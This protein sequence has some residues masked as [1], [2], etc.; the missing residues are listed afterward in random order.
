MDGMV[1]NTMRYIDDRLTLNV[2]LLRLSSRASAQENYGKSHSTLL[3][4]VVSTPQQFMIK[5]SFNFNIVN[6]PQTLVRIARICSKF[7][8]PDTGC[9]ALKTRMVG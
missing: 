4:I 2:Q 8:Y 1:V 3:M 9:P 6:F 5:G 7:V